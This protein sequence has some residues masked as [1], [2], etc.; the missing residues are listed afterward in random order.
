LAILFCQRL[1]RK[2]MASLFL[3]FSN[4]FDLRQLF[5]LFVRKNFAALRSNN[6]KQAFPPFLL[7]WILSCWL[8]ASSFSY[9]QPPEARLRLS[10]IIA[11]A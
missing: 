10:A 9:L 4:E 8:H 1:K 2:K 6:L 5:Y 7:K 11:P 3:Y